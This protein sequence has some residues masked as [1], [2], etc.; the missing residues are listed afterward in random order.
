MRFGYYFDLKARYAGPDE[1]APRQL[2]SLMLQRMHHLI[3]QDR[4][5][6]A[7]AV[8]PD[9]EGLRLFWADGLRAAEARGRLAGI[10][11]F[12]D[13]VQIGE[14]QEVPATFTGPWVAWCRYRIPTARSDR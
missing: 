12:R 8:L 4:Q 9:G 5:G 11:L 6:V 7:L 1:F 14:V 2:R 13:Y 3:A 10:P